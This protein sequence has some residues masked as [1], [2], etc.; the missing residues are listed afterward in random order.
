MKYELFVLD[1]D[2]TYDIPDPDNDNFPTVYFIPEGTAHK[3]C[4]LADLASE[5]FHQI[6]DDRA[7]GD[8]FEELLIENCITFL[9]VGDLQIPFNER[10][11]DYLADS[12]CHVV[13]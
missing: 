7:I 8:I 6:D 5:T 12:I 11:E 4:R 1:F 10:Q 13:V 3:V 2:G 9:H